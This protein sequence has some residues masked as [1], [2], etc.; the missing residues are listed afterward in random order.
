MISPGVLASSLA[1]MR[2]RYQQA[3]ADAGLAGLARDFGISVDAPPMGSFRTL[4]QDCQ[5]TVE[6]VARFLALLELY[7]EGAVAFDQMAPLGELWVRWTGAVGTEEPSEDE[8]MD[9]EYG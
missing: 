1:P 8:N 3:L 4:T 5:H 2:A 7:R 9:E 6:M